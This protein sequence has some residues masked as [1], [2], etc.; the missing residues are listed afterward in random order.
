MLSA[1]KVRE[2][3]ESALKCDDDLEKKIAEAIENDQKENVNTKEKAS[4]SFK[5]I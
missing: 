4:H 3:F 5:D 1:A 2:G